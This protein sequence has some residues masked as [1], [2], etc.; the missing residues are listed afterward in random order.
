MHLQP[1]CLPFGPRKAIVN[2]MFKILYNIA[3][4]S[5]DNDNDMTFVGHLVYLCPCSLLGSGANDPTQATKKLYAL[6]KSCYCPIKVA[7]CQMRE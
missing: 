1:A 4:C 5:D 3:L 7:N 6:Q 2:K